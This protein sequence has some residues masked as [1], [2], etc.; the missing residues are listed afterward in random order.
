MPNY[1][2]IAE[3]VQITGYTPRHIA[4]LLRQ[5]QVQ[6]KKIGRIWLVD[7][8]DL[9]RHLHEMN[10]LGTKKYDPTKGRGS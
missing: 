3:A 1:V 7:L 9:E 6:G 4:L 10:E 2:L 5:G 8:D